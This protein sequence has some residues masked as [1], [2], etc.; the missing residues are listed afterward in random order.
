MDFYEEVVEF[1]LTVIEGC[2]VI[3]QA[4]ILKNKEGDDWI[5]FPDFVAI[6]FKEQRIEII[7]VTKSVYPRPVKW[8]ARKL[9]PDYRTNVESYV[10]NT[11]V[12]RQLRLPIHW[13]FF[14][15]QK[16][17]ETLKSQDSFKQFDQSLVHVD[18]LEG[19][20]DKIR[21]IMP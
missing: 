20:F 19:V 15:R 11:T 14:V 13:R 1:Y 18:A 4:P 2:A 8:L 6:N 10:T 17:V 16:Q 9:L 5:A 21:D 7:E 3:P 12:A